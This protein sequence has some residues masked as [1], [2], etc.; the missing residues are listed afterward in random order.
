[1]R[2]FLALDIS[3]NWK[4]EIFEV[5]NQLL[6]KAFRARPIARENLHLTM[7]FIGDISDPVSLIHVLDELPLNGIKLLPRGLASFK[8][9]RE[10]LVYLELEETR[11]LLEF[12]KQVRRALDS[13]GQV[14][15]KKKFLP[16]ISI[17]RGVEFEEGFSLEQ[18]DI[19]LDSLE[20]KSLK[21][22]ESKLGP[23]G[24]SYRV[25][26]SFDLI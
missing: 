23:R 17:M 4:R 13:I 15:D 2:V 16:H 8:R 18:V 25:I 1:M 3:E 24:A 20:V 10:E 14:Y 9:P 26:K 12:N 21:L 11:E 5:Q 22:Y 7:Q 19:N 6:K